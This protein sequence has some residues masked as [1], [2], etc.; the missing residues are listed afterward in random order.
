M[1]DPDHNSTSGKS[2][3]IIGFSATADELI[4]VIVVV[5]EGVEYGANGWASNTKDS[6]IYNEGSY[7]TEAGEG[8]GQAD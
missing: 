2:V 7:Q 1:I 8:D 3:R 5:D 4:T 6:H